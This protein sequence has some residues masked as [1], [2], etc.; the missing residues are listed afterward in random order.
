[1]KSCERRISQLHLLLDD[2]LTSGQEEEL[3]EHLQKCEICAGRMRELMQMKAVVE[4]RL[5]AHIA[6]PDDES[7]TARATGATERHRKADPSLD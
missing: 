7:I 2:E 3:N 1:M 4:E 6:L 5:D